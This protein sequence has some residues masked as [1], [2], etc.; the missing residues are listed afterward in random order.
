MDLKNIYRVLHPVTA[1]YTFFAATHGTF[2]KIDILGHKA[3]FNTYNK[4]EIKHFVLSDHNR[5]KLELNNKRNSRKYSNTWRQ[6]NTLLHDR[7][8]KK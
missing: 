1:Q 2:S 3:N 5:I 4:I 7:S 6:N 8:S